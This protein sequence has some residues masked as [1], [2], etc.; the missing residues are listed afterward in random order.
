M[1]EAIELFKNQEAIFKMQL[2]PNRQFSK[3]HV[4]NSHELSNIYIEMNYDE[5]KTSI[6]NFFFLANCQKYFGTSKLSNPPNV[7]YQV[8]IS[9]A[10]NTIII[11]SFQNRNSCK[12]SYIKM[13]Q[14]SVY[15]SLLKNHS[16]GIMVISHLKLENS[17]YK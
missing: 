5:T 10:Y 3:L 2:M 16:K 9:I 4:R 6:S 11:L 17:K 12:G 7:Y 13:A 15:M 1:V 8:Q 14:I